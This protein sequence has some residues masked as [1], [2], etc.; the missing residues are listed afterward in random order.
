MITA[1]M[2]ARHY[3]VFGGM[4]SSETPAP[5]AL[6][7]LDS[8]RALSHWCSSAYRLF[9]CCLP[10]YDRVKL[11]TTFCSLLKGQCHLSGN[12]ITA[13]YPGLKVLEHLVDT[14]VAEFDPAIVNRGYSAADRRA[15]WRTVGRDFP[16]PELVEAIL[17]GL[18]DSDGLPMSESDHIV[19]SQYP[20]TIK[21]LATRISESLQNGKRVEMPATEIEEAAQ[22]PD[23]EQLKGIQEA[24]NS[25]LDLCCYAARTGHDVYALADYVPVLLRTATRDKL[26]Y[27]GLRSFSLVLPI[28]D[29]TDSYSQARA[30]LA[31]LRKAI[32]GYQQALAAGQESLIADAYAEVDKARQNSLKQEFDGEGKRDLLTVTCLMTAICGKPLRH[33]LPDDHFHLSLA[34]QHRRYL[35]ADQTKAFELLL[36]AVLLGIR[37]LG[38]ESSTGRS[39]LASCAMQ[40]LLDFTVLSQC[41]RLSLEEK[42]K[43][44][45]GTGWKRIKD[46]IARLGGGVGK[47]LEYL[48]ECVLARRNILAHPADNATRVAPTRG[49]TLSDL[50]RLVD[51]IRILDCS[52]PPTV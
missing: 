38:T 12:P 17:E 36:D 20:K 9:Y 29:S 35:S 26:N 11:D 27:T 7:D 2:L 50:C 10:L 43:Q 8:P 41:K 22:L 19:L 40:P 1:A 32:G 42:N 23:W 15:G 46:E 28:I 18:R 5:L 45:L 21:I 34:V 3:F 16:N 25:V 4:P 33:F 24:L 39:L 13:V 47:P 52:I 30:S 31:G 49:E 44:M 6:V 37:D 14:G 51:F 48:G